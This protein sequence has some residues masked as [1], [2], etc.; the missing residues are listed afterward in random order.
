MRDDLSRGDGLIIFLYRGDGRFSFVSRRRRRRRFPASPPARVRLDQDA[1]AESQ[2]FARPPSFGTMP[3]S[4]YRPLAD[5]ILRHFCVE[6]VFFSTY[7]CSNP[8]CRLPGLL[9]HSSC[10][11]PLGTA[12]AQSYQLKKQDPPTGG[13]QRY[14]RDA[15][16]LRT[17]QSGK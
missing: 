10:A 15:R 13:P 8:T 7:T 1:R 9:R 5:Y 11:R 16:S 12:S 3:A 2:G 17:H 14:R 6:L 4:V